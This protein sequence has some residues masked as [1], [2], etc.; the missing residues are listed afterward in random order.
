MDAPSTTSQPRSSIFSVDPLWTSSQ[1]TPAASSSPTSRASSMM[2]VG[3]QGVEGVVAGVEQ[4]V[5]TPQRRHEPPSLLV[6][7][8]SIV[9]ARSATCGSV[10]RRS[11]AKPLEARPIPVR[12]ER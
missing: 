12:A 6:A 5:A 1:A 9:Q 4:L 7:E 10:G 3:L 2:C 11:V 8:R